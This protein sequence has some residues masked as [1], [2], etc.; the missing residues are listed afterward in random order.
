MSQNVQISHEEY[1][2]LVLY[3]EKYEKLLVDSEI[4]RLQAELAFSEKRN[5]EIMDYWDSSIAFGARMREK[6]HNSEAEIE[7]LRA[8]NLKLREQLAQLAQQLAQLAQQAE[9]ADPAAKR[10]KLK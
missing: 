1:D 5:E 4:E 2:Q 3:K 9:P 7:T 6:Y 8:E 10:M